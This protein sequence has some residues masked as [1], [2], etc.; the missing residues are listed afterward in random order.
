[1]QGSDADRY[2]KPGPLAELSDSC[3]CQVYDP[4][5]RGFEVEHRASLPEEAVVSLIH[6][7]FVSKSMDPVS[8]GKG[9]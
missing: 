5:V 3:L 2:A 9:V 1:M 8:M 6:A 4:A 7:G